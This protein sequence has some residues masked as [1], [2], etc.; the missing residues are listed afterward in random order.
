MPNEQT[1]AGAGDAPSVPDA[2]AIAAEATARIQAILTCDEAKGRSQMAQHLAFQTKMSADEA[3][4]LLAVS[5][6]TGEDSGGQSGSYDQR[7]ETARA[8]AQPGGGGGKH[9]ASINAGDIYARRAS[10]MKG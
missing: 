2:A 9:T 7:R 8:Q 10:A 5:P 6:E 4:A 3:K 1:A